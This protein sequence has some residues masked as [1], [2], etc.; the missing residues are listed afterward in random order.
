MSAQQPCRHILNASVFYWNIFKNAMYCLGDNFIKVC[1][2]ISLRSHC[3]GV[4][5]WSLFCYLLLC[6]PLV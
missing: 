6:V 4:L 1:K 2:V 3:V 5:P